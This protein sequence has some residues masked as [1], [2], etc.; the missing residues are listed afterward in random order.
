MPST[1]HLICTVA[2]LGGLL[3]AG[4]ASPSKKEP[5]APAQA[6]AGPAKP[7]PTN[8]SPLILSPEELDRRAE[9][10]A[11][12]ASAIIHELNEEP[13][14]AA[15][16]LYQ[17]ALN[18]LENESLVLDVTRRLL[19]FKKND[20]ALD[21]LRKATERPDAPGP[22]YA[23]LGLVYA[24]GDKKEEAIEA[25]RMAIRK[26]PKSFA[27]YQN[28]G[29]MYLQGNQPEEGMKVL[30][31][32]AKQSGVDAAFLIDL[33]EMYTAFSVSSSG[34]N[35][36]AKKQAL[37]TLDRAAKLNP[38]N[39]AQLQKMGDGFALLNAPE[40]AEEVYRKLLDR[41]PNLPGLR[42]KLAEIY[43]RKQD[44][45][46]AAEQLEAIIRNTP[47]NPQAHYFLGGIQ[48]EQKQWK[49]AA[50]HYQSAILVNA[51]FEP[52][53]YD[54]ALAQINLNT[55]QEALAT[56]EKAKKRF[57]ETFTGEFF[58]AIAY[59]KMKEYSNAIPRFTA[60]EVIGRAT[61]T[62]RLT[63]V[64]YYQMGAAYERAQSF[65]EAERYL[66]KA[67]GLS[68]DFTEAMNYLGYM[69]AERGVNLKEARTLIEQAVKAEPKN[70]A[71]LD[72]LGWVLFKLDQPK[73]ALSW[74]LKAIEY[75]EEPDATLY[76]HLG[77]I[78]A[79]MKENGKAQEAWKKSVELEPKDEVKKK[80]GTLA[81]P[82]SSEGA[83]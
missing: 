47:T 11:R 45:A 22:L 24:L 15:D 43:L 3:F 7:E 50:D 68:A 18:D 23:R 29:R 20:K 66:R 78:Y 54:L 25:N 57:K 46:K 19:Q 37:A 77:D 28:L 48:F 16:E 42:E 35:A 58:A 17:A 5:R 33:A 73:E 65:E 60:A 62:N 52:A 56:L 51:A 38:T 14:L 30:D 34:Q 8:G 67:L 2:A 39:P 27:G 76:D 81:G 74:M 32:A 61:D 36:E 4:C 13:E 63:H 72:S 10:H 1:F 31:Q 9:A 79:A 80:L 64:F 41:F 82:D 70:A 69:W 26:M 53:Y 55:P 71:Y 59:G 49:E 40:K 6:D 12:Y 21:L 44:R 75:S 83:P